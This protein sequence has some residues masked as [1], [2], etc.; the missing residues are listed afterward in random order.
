MVVYGWVVNNLYKLF[1]FK[2]IVLN[3]FNVFFESKINKK[4]K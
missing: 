3:L 2:K 4:L 1:S